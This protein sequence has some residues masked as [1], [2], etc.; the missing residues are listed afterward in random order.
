M[1]LSVVLYIFIAI[2]LID[3]L[4]NTLVWWQQ[5]KVHKALVVFTEAMKILNQTG[6]SDA[7]P[8]R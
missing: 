1:A 6:V 2:L 5:R 7:A 3:A 4:L 8:K